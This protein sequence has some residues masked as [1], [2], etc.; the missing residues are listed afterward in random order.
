MDITDRLGAYMGKVSYSGEVY[1]RN[2]KFVGTVYHNGSVRDLNG[3]EVGR[4]DSHGDIYSSASKEG[5]VYSGGKVRD[6]NVDYVG[7]VSG[8]TE[9]SNTEDRYLAGG[10]ALLL[11]LKPT[12]SGKTPISSKQ[13]GGD[14]G[15]STLQPRRN[16]V[17]QTI[18]QRTQGSNRKVGII[19]GIV[20]V[21]VVLAL[22]LLVLKNVGQSSSQLSSNNPSSNS[23]NNVSSNPYGGT[24]VLN[25]PLQN[26]SMGYQWEED[27]DNKGDFC[28]FKSGA[29]HVG[30]AQPGSNSC[31]AAAPSFDNFAFQV[32]VIPGNAKSA[33]IMFRLHRTLDSSGAVTALTGYEFNLQIGAYDFRVDNNGQSSELTSGSLPGS[34]QY[35]QP[36]QIAVVAKSSTFDLYINGQHVGSVSDSTFSSGQLGFLVTPSPAGAS[37]E[38]VYSNAKVWK[39]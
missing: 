33:G 5:S 1:D 16:T 29:Y 22:L 34:Y 15:F 23:S 20:A 13:P 19:A 3:Y 7:D 6:S 8:I 11:L 30:I 24:L 25:D 14:T 32:T 21:F 17:P 12:V 9:Y 36:N 39:M 35:N 26:N 10:A 38:V 2:S 28:Q 4:V 37:T 31:I 27:N 18:T